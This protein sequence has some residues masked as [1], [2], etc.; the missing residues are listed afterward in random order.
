MD[1]RNKI[2]H[3]NVSPD[4]VGKAQSYMDMQRR[5]NEVEEICKH[6][7]ESFSKYIQQ[8]DYLK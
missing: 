8:K 7:I 3:G 5:T 6:I 4:E 2:A 1:N